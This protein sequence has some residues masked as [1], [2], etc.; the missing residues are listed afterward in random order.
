VGRPLLA[1]QSP[2]LP[3]G[4]PVGVIAS[5]INTPGLGMASGD[6]ARCQVFRKLLQELKIRGLRLCGRFGDEFAVIH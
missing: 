3:T 6:D 1:S 2:P 4:A 5:P